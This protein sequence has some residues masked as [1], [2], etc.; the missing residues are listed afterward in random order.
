MAKNLILNKARYRENNDEF[1]TTY[2]T[3][4]KEIVH[5]E[6]SLENKIILCNC[7]DPFESNFSKY[8]IK[9]FNRLKLKKLICTS[10]S[11][12]KIIHSK[13]D[14]L[15]SFGENLSNA[16]G[17]IL[18]I[19]EVPKSITSDSLDKEILEW[20]RR[21]KNV[22][23]LEENGDFR[24]RECIEILK[25]S[26]I[27]I[28]NPPFSLFRDLIKIIQ[29]H[30]KQFLL[31]GNSNAITYKEIFPMIQNNEAWLGHNYGDM[32][33]RVPDDAEER[34]TRFWIDENGK[35][36]RSLG[37]AMWLTNI[38]INRRHQKIM[39]KKKY[40]QESYP[41]YDLYDAIEVSK[42][43][44][45]PIDYKGIMGVPITFLNKHN[46]AQFDIIG[47]ANHGSDNLFDLFKPIINGKLV[48]KRILIKNKNLRE[49]LVEW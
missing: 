48:Y 18:K 34:K 10:Y 26:D 21:K 15:D 2:K 8:F 36:W 9:N 40:N 33:F 22:K 41:N 25:K 13:K 19:S 7:D 49:G 3:I 6:K 23:N 39:L 47:E 11:S 28:T 17:F 14:F 24:S 32:E 29:E 31:I 35:K 4:E 43:A 45:I 5:Y 38:D 12:S 20:M 37:N 30:K 1:Y 42:V 16:K 27:I 44:D 46:P